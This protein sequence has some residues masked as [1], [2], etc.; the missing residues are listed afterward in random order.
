VTVA[1]II[2]KLDPTK[3]A[4][5]QIA[6]E[7]EKHMKTVHQMAEE[8]SILPEE[9]LPMG[10]H[11]GKVDFAAV[12]K[13]LKDRPNAKYIDV[14]AITPTPLGEGKSTTTMGLV[15]GLAQRGKNVSGAIRQPSGGPTFNI[16]GSAAGGGLSQCIPLTPFSLGLTGDID[17]VVNAHNLA[18]VAVTSRLQHEFI[19][20]DEFLAKRNLK[21]LNIDPRN[22]E[23]RWI[24][25]FCAQA[26]R[27]IVIGIWP[28]Y[29]FLLI[30]KTSAS[31]CLRLLL[32]MTNRATL[33]PPETLKWTGP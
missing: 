33:L 32:P 2:T 4:D 3:L 9:L 29:Q 10:H 16:K 5:W 22:V 13:R 6:E 19:N 12:L 27:D 20:T 31:A 23:M 14:T 1:D 18:M 17:N 30:L 24:I 7:V 8:W 11:L 25:D 21:R 28:Y 26:L 15:Q